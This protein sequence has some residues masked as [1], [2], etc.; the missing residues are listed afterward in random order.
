[1]VYNWLLGCGCEKAG[2]SMKISYELFCRKL[3]AYGGNATRAYGKVYPKAS[4]ES[5]RHG[6]WR[7]CTYVDI[8]HRLIEIIAAEIDILAMIKQ[9][10]RMTKATKKYKL[11]GDSICINDPDYRT[12]LRALGIISKLIRGFKNKPIDDANND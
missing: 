4:Y 3:I 12:Q 8:R 6:G 1:M 10:E 9:L 7:L 2:A 5:A 11:K